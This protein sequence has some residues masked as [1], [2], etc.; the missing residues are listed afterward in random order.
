MNVDGVIDIYRRV[1][2]SEDITGDSD[3]FEL[4]GDSLLATR[5]LSGIARVSGVELSFD[6]FL[7]APTP[8]ALAKLVS[9]DERHL[10]TADGAR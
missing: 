5:V 4:G 1:L 10:N 9:S 3:F 7:L 6:D 2:E 8:D